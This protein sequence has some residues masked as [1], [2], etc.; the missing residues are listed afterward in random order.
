MIVIFKKGFTLI[1]LLIVMAILG[2]LAVVVL[3][4]INP[5][6]QLARTRD[7][8]RKSTVNQ[9]GRVL[10]SYFTSRATY[11]KAA[12]CANLNTNWI[13][14]LTAVGLLKSVPAGITYQFGNDC[15]LATPPATYG[16]QNLWCYSVS[17]A[18]DTAVVFAT[19]ESNSESSK[20]DTAGQQPYFVWSSVDGK[21]CLRCI[22]NVLNPA[23]RPAPGSQPCNTKQ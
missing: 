11:L 18:G 21:S 8:G 7:T 20:C 17:A 15:T 2:V 3:V 6:Q 10:I 1:E 9:V 5:T 13:D 16:Q 4:A 14:C 19:L 23:A 22:D 12:N